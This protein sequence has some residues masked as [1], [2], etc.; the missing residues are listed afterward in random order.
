MELATIV[1]F[2]FLALLIAWLGLVAWGT[3][4]GIDRD[5]EAERRRR[6]GRY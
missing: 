1:V 5:L 6:H 2:V 3:K 4:V